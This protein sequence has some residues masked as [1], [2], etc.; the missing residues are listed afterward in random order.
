MHVLYDADV[1][2]P[3]MTLEAFGRRVARISLMMCAWRRVHAGAAG[4]LRAQGVYCA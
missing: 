1:V 4:S 3:K 2:M